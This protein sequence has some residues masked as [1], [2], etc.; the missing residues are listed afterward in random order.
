MTLVLLNSDP[1][2]VPLGGGRGEGLGS[3]EFSWT[4]ALV[5]DLLA[6]HNNL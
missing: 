2:P 6:A 4:A 1:R 3:E 5:L